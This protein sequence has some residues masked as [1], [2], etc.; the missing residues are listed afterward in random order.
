[1]K[2]A[3]V[4]AGNWGKNIVRTL[5]ELNTLGAIVDPSEAIR[6]SFASLAP[7]FESID[8]V[9]SNEEINAV[10]IATPG[11]THYQAARQALLAGKDVFVEKPLVLSS[12]EGEELCRIAEETG[13]IL[14][15]GHLLIYQ[16][17]IRFMKEQLDKGIIGKVK[18]LHQERLN[19]GRARQFENVLWSIGVHD[20]ASALYLVGD[21]P[22]RVQMTGQNVLQPE[23][24]DDI[25]VHMSFENNVL[26]HIHCSW[27]WPV[28]RRQ[29]T[30]VGEKGMLVFDEP[31]QSIRLHKKR[32]DENLA[33]VDEGEEIIF[34]NKGKALTLELEHFLDCCKTRK[35][36]ITD[37]R[38]AVEVLRVM[39]RA[40]VSAS[41]LTT[42]KEILVEDVS[43]GVRI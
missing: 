19:L 42:G 18:S 38:S 23:I 24:A 35:T 17:A 31:S 34:E 5:D 36:P 15:V 9:L 14:M 39:E 25:Y 26:V 37:G 32:I 27:L 21:S 4:G 41:D 10:A 1:V 3:V 30:V 40:E 11:H 43:S 7:T 6:E 28:L 12:A 13:R 16:P 20:I 2:V 22:I 8:A 29:L 33:N